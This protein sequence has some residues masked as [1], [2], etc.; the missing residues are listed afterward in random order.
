MTRYVCAAFARHHGVG[1]TARQNFYDQYTKM[2]GVSTI[3]W[4]KKAFFYQPLVEKAVKAVERTVKAAVATSNA[5]TAPKM[6]P[7]CGRWPF[8][9]KQG[10]H[11]CTV[12]ARFPVWG[13]ATPHRPFGGR[14]AA[15]EK[16]THG[17]K[18]QYIL[19]T[20]NIFCEK[21]TTAPSTANRRCGVLCAKDRAPRPTPCCFTVLFARWARSFST[22]LVF[23]PFAGAP[24]A[25][26]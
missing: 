24:S 19:K 26:S 6:R 22:Y 20:E 23:P 1:R 12:A 16:R 11:R 8:R 7:R 9:C 18:R 17:Q 15:V 14:P 2:R 13:T 25:S 3:L 21:E 10:G 5:A 4:L